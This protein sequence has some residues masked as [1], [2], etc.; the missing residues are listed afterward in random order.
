MM[1]IAPT[2]SPNRP[3]NGESFPHEG[4]LGSALWRDSNE[5][6][7]EVMSEG[8]EAT[9]KMSGSDIETG[10]GARESSP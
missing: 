3:L 7:F 6:E 8:D 1:K 5:T 2:R 10:E 4:S 9:E